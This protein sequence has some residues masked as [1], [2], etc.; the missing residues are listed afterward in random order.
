MKIFNLAFIIPTEFSWNGEK[1]YYSSLISALDK[2]PQ[3]NIKLKIFLGKKNHRFIKSL[4]IKNSQIIYSSLFEKNSFSNFINK[5]FFKI[6]KYYN[7]LLIMYFKIYNI[8]YISHYIPLY[9]FKNIVWYPD[10]QHLH[11]K[12]FFSKQDINF[13]NSLYKNYT[14]N[15][16]IH[17]VSSK[18]SRV[19]LI[20]FNKKNNL[21]KININVLN[22]VPKINFEKIINFKKLKKKYRIE[23]NY[24]YVPNQFWVHKNHI[25]LFKSL[26]ILK[27]KSKH[28][29]L[30]LTGSSKDHR[31]KEY[32][33]MLFDYV[34][35]KKIDSSIKYL[36]VIP[37]DHAM[38][39]LYYCR[40]LINPSLFEG[41]S[42]TVEEGKILNKKMLLS[43]IDVHKEQTNKNVVFFKK[44]DFND[45]ARQILKTKP[46][47]FKSNF[48]LKKD[49]EIKR[50][51]FANTFF[52]IIS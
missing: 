20:N 43:N 49:F 22:F 31:N 21:K 27:K 6:F 48:L 33:K 13:R 9:G 4:K 47:K 42:S 7:V 44:R 25:T 1:N 30:I 5:F 40:L 26:E 18:S 45:L 41:W 29:Q 50:K 10:F 37:Y 24:T 3:K 11:L 16:D 51:L 39:L 15:G 38:S 12:K 8:N 2:Y 32:F 34:L 17:I 46:S 52:K 35:K 19:D 14:L 28:I 23:K 36:G